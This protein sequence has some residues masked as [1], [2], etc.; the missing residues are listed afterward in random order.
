MTDQAESHSPPD[1]RDRRLRPI[2]P[3]GRIASIDVVRG[4]AVLG[5]LLMNILVFGLP[6]DAYDSDP[7][8]IG[9]AE[10]VNVMVWAANKVLVKGA[11]RTVFSMLFGAGVI[12]LTARAE[13]RGAQVQLADVYYR[14]ILWLLVFGVAHAYLLLYWGDILFCYAISGLFLF[15]FR[16]LPARA[17]LAVGLA[18]L[19]VGA[20]LILPRYFEL[21]DREA[22]AIAAEVAAAAGEKLTQEQEAARKQWRRLSTVDREELQQEIDTFRSDYR[23]IFKY[24]AEINVGIQ[25][26][27]IYRRT[28]WDTA[29][30]MLLGMGLFKLGVFSAGRSARFYLVLM[31]TGYALGLSLNGYPAYEIIAHNFDPVWG[32]LAYA[33]YDL[34]RLAVGLGHLGMVLLIYKLGRPRW[35]IASLAA[36]GRMA[37]SNYIGPTIV[38]SLLFFGFGFGLF[39]TLERFELYYVVFAIWVFQLIASPVWLRYFRF[40]PCEWL[41]RSL[42]YWRRQPMRVRRGKKSDANAGRRLP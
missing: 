4:F 37:L 21:R 10:D 1:G 27:S 15:P 24:V 29:G 2:G 34:G 18:V 7:T 11:M 26:R 28:F 38:C 39:A 9:Q 14:R 12:L 33:Y 8:I 32:R 3:A 25:S 17:L 41:W 16:K 31:G 42:T 36:V 40:G 13:A 6:G 19:A 20:V 30:M 5:I 23:T 35:L 22:A